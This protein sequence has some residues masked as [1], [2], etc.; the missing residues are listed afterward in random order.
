M[1]PR[2]MPFNFAN[3]KIA[4]EK[5]IIEES[6]WKLS[7]DNNRECYHC[8]ANHPALGVSIHPLDL[9]CEIEGMS[10]EELD[11]W[12]AHVASTSAQEAHWEAAGFPSSLIEEMSG[13]ET[14]FRTQRFAIAGEGEPHTMDTNRPSK[15]LLG[16][17]TNAKLGDL[18]F[19]TH[20]SWHHVFA[21][22]AVVNYIVPL[23]PDRTELRAVWLVHKEAVE[24]V[25]Y[26]VEHLTTVWL[27]TN[28]EDADLVKITQLG[29]KTTGYAPGP[30][31]ESLERLV[32]LNMRWYIER[33]KAHG[34]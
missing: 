18:H 7:I 20:N 6:N 9:T 23:G 29:V 34:Y 12:N 30:L 22:H 8:A 1:K 27:E 3:A 24:G 33:L 21:D 28:Q 19:W 16:N 14:I 31:S 5:V 13:R 2:L 17:L 10:P 4:Y 26:D 15:R 32:E 11:E 25:D